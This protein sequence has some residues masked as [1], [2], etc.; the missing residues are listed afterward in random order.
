[1]LLAHAIVHVARLL[2]CDEKDRPEDYVGY[3]EAAITYWRRTLRCRPLTPG[4]KYPTPSVEVTH[5]ISSCA[6]LPQFQLLDDEGAEANASGFQIVT[7]QDDGF[8]LVEG[9]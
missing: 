9:A 7:H 8:Q 1:M 6:A 2:N 5:G 4:L 3:N